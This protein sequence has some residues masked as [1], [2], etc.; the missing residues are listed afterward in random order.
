MMYDVYKDEVVVLLYNKFSM[1]ALLSNR[2]HDFTF[3]NHHFIRLDADQISNNQLDLTAGFYEQLY[4][5]KTEI[6][7]RRIKAIQTTT[8][9]SASPETYFYERNDYY[10]KKGNTYHKISSKGSILKILKDKKSELQ[11]Y[12]KQNDINY[13]DNPEN[14][15]A[16]IASYYDRLTN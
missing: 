9:V 10:L 12:L 13:G 14:A 2:V 4:A 3:S 15:M 8:N 6:L 11:K 5:G 16:R 7:A 1:F